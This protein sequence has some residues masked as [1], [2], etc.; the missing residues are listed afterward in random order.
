MASPVKNHRR[1]SEA[2]DVRDGRVMLSLGPLSAKKYCTFSCAFCYVQA[3]FASYASLEVE[4]IV[5]WVKALKEPYDVIY[6]SGDT[7]SFAKP[8]TEAGLELLERLTAFGVDLLFTTRH[9]FDGE[10]LDRLQGIATELRGRGQFLFGCTSIA[11]IRNGYLEPRPIPPPRER[12]TQLERFRERGLVSVLA[13]RPFLPVVPPSEYVELAR[14]AAGKVDAILGE[15]WY[16]DQAGLLER[17]VFRDFPP[18]PPVSSEV[19]RMD[20]DANDAEWRI[21]AQPETEEEVRKECERLDTPFFMRSR[22]A[23]QY[24]RALGMDL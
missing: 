5:E 19:R 16:A 11:Q 21:Y 15:V 3:D 8:R 7:D 6:V 1:S 10:G 9:V 20:F 18:H 4:E 17:R 12:L 23:I 22:P 14:L 24:I 13:M 2:F